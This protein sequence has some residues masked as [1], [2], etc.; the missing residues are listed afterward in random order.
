MMISFM[1]SLLFDSIDVN[2]MP[3]VLL[4]R[5]VSQQ[6]DQKR[7]FF[8]SFKEWMEISLL[9]LLYNLHL[10]VFVPT[11]QPTH[12]SVFVPTFHTSSS[13]SS[14]HYHSSH[15]KKE[16]EVN[17]NICTW[18]GHVTVGVGWSR[19]MMGHAHWYVSGRE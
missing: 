9:C 7:R 17:V 12:L 14:F 15:K 11:L 1:M 16:I 6:R 13:Y 8:S 2:T 10:T 4:C 3:K 18:C 19:D 5:A